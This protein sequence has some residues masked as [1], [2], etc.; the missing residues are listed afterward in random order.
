MKYVVLKVGEEEVDIKKMENNKPHPLLTEFCDRRM[1]N[2][3][4]ENAT[5]LAYA[6]G[7]HQ[8]VVIAHDMT[9]KERQH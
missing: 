9:K 8:G 1:N 3:V 5:K 2:L 4:M 7:L 6:T